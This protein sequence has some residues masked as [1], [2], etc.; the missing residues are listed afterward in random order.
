LE[1]ARFPNAH[2]DVVTA[3]EL[4][5]HVPEPSSLIAEI[6][7]ILRPGGILW[8]TT[9]HSRGASAR[10]L[11]LNWNV[12]GPPEHLH[13][14]SVHGITRLLSSQ[15]FRGV[16]VATE[17]V[18][19]TDLLRSLRSQQAAAPIVVPGEANKRVEAAYQWNEMLLRNP[20]RRILK[21][22]VN[23]ALRASRLGDSLKVWA[24]H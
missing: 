14:F 2:F 18:N 8:A 24:E 20:R 3:S 23:A 7:R 21:N 13:L 4:L 17:A 9:P 16:R 22:A 1:E 19:P 5:E 11:K 15:G 10:L 12:I 6:A